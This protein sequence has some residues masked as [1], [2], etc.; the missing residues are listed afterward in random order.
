LDLW[1]YTL[2]GPLI[3]KG[4]LKVAYKY[5]PFPH[6]INPSLPLLIFAT[7]SSS[8][9]DWLGFPRACLA[10]HQKISMDDT[11][12][13]DL[14]AGVM[15]EKHGHDHPCG[16]KNKPKAVSS[17]APAKQHPGRPL[18][19]KNKSK[20]STSQVNEPLDVSAAH[21]NPLPPST[22]TLLSF[23][24]LAG[25]Q[26]REQHR[27]PLKFTEFMDG[28]ELREAILREVSS[29]GPP[30][31]VDVYYDGDGE[32]FFKG[33][34]PRFTEDYDLHQGWFLLFNYHCGTT[35]FDMNFSDG[36]QCQKKYEAEVYF[37]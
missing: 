16:N 11:R 7:T 30:Y 18:G 27:V 3:F 23:F 13:V 5:G 24:A 9:P 36:T 19:S 12:V 31:E 8:S 37:H 28:Q 1:A 15:A 10:I 32:M 25:A 6:L 34:W 35:K 17:S 26:Y 21:L 33:G 4:P 29:G 14:D 2:S 22:G 20:S